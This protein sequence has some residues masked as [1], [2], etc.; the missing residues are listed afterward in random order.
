MA[1]CSVIFGLILVCLQNVAKVIVSVSS[2]LHYWSFLQVFLYCCR[3]I[4]DQMPD[5]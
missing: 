5:V 3:G 4:T 2:L 1:K